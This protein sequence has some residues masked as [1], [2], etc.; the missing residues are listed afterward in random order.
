MCVIVCEW[1]V[2]LYG[3][4]IMRGARVRDCVCVCN[5]GVRLCG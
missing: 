3:C 2:L 1:G 5:R 4:V